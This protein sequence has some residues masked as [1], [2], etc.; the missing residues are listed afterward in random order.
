MPDSKKIRAFALAVAAFCIAA[1][2]Y[3]PEAVDAVLVAFAALV[4]AIVNWR[5]PKP[6]SSGPAQPLARIVSGMV[7]L[8]CLAL[9]LVACSGAQPFAEQAKPLIREATKGYTVVQKVCVFAQVLDG[10]MPELDAAELCSK[11]EFAR[12]WLRKLEEAAAIVEAQRA[13]RPDVEPPPVPE[14]APP[15]ATPAPS[16]APSPSATP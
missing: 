1:T 3:T 14:C 10:R 12:P 5:S 2:K 11:A 16:F 15:A 6:P 8:L 7:A 4:N 13:G 9:L